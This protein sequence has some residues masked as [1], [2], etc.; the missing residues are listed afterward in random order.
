[1][2]ALAIRP[3]SPC[4][5]LE[6]SCGEPPEGHLAPP[7]DPG[8]AFTYPGP[9]PGHR[10]L[11]LTRLRSNDPAANL[12]RTPASELNAQPA[13]DAC[14]RMRY[15]LRGEGV[16]PRPSGSPGRPRARGGGESGRSCE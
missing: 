6:R 11:S 15:S 9:N 4:R 14:A 5:S 13:L 16:P 8:P 7:W 2:G 12:A 3:A 1:M 10:K